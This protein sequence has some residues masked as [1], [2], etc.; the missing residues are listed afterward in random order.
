MQ[1]E[2]V[3]YAH[4]LELPRLDPEGRQAE[5]RLIR[6]K[7]LTRMRLKGEDGV[8]GLEVAGLLRRGGNHRLVAA[9]DAVE[10][11]ERNDGA[12]R[13]HWHFRM[14]PKQ[15]HGPVSNSSFPRCHSRRR[16]TARAPANAVLVRRAP[17]ARP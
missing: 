11:A 2:Q 10:I 1:H 7:K 5:G 6:S 14:M 8:G 13:L 3:V 17:T 16:A 12:A 9:M 15:P 4:G